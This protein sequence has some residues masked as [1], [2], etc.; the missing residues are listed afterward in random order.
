MKINRRRLR[1]IIRESFDIMTVATEI[2][3]ELRGFDQQGVANTLA[4]NYTDEGGVH[5]SS[6]YLT[7][8][9]DKLL[10]GIRK[11]GFFRGNRGSIDRLERAVYEW[12]EQYPEEAEELL[13]YL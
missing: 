3:E 7:P 1:R 5:L 6:G 8:N 2:V 10:K 13:A 12:C 4:G 9:A 11:T